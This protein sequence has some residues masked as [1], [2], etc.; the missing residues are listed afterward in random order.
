MSHIPTIDISA[1]RKGSKEEK[2][3]IASEVDTICQTTGF[4]VI[5]GHGV[6]EDILEAAWSN[7]WAFF[8]LP[9][10]QKLRS[11]SSEPGCPRGYFPLEMEALA[12]TQGADTP[13]D[14]KEMFSIGQHRKP[15]HL[16][17][18]SDGDFFFGANIWPAEPDQLQQAWLAYYTAMERLGA[19]LMTL[20]AAA[21]H[22][23]EAYFTPHHTTTISA[24]RASNY[25]ATDKALQPGQ[26]R[27]GAH[28]DYGSLTI[29]KSDIAVGGLEVLMPTGEW[30]MA[31]RIPDSF[32]INIGDMMA[33]W[34]N[35]RWV[36]TL[37]RVV[38]PA[39]DEGGLSKR[40]QSLAFFYQPDWDAEIKCIS[41]C[42]SAG[43]QPKF[44]MVQSGP[45]LMQRFGVSIDQPGHT[46]G[47][48]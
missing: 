37:H 36:S 25:P 7:A 48:R 6:P 33:R 31:P 2:Q 4:L 22:L 28:S 3:A 35:D 15:G 9:M 18:G 12:K 19:D 14:L 44:S 46:P 41:T 13:P 21:L 20:F 30:A 23:P 8:D 17:P 39:A 16:P 43:E 24:L 32:I 45:Y 47:L 34:T 11:Q 26:Q 27:A 10:E 40:R 42:L 5:T 38:S 1:F 29:L